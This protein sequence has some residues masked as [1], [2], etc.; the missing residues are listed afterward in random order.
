M[1]DDEFDLEYLRCLR[2]LVLDAVEHCTRLENVVL[3]TLTSGAD[4]ESLNSALDAGY[5]TLKLLS[6]QCA[7]V[8]WLVDRRRILTGWSPSD[9]NTH[10]ESDTP[11]HVS[12]DRAR[13]PIVPRVPTGL[14]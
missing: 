1:E 10:S 12:P 13:T 2:E 9:S 11:G 14:Q 7:H 6:H 4:V 8:E 3:M 5:R